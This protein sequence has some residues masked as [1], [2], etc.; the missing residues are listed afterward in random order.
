MNF[1]LTDEQRMLRDMVERLAVE[2]H[3]FAVRRTAVA[4]HHGFHRPFWTELGALGILGATLPEDCG[5]LG[6]GSVAAMLIMSA[7]GKH[8][9]ISPYVSTVICAA[10][11]IA[12]VGTLAQRERYLASIVEGKTIVAFAYA[13]R[14]DDAPVNRV[15]ALASPVA[16]GFEINAHKT[17]VVGAIWSGQVM[18]VTRIAGEAEAIAAFLLPMN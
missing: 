11:L 8:L 3:S 2:R 12:R 18:V 6:A 17:L 13:E 10:G 9:V 15:E 4:E 16:G 14:N 5:G 1:T 7:F